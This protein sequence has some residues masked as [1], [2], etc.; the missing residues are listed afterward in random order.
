MKKEETEIT[1]NDKK[2]V[3]VGMLLIIA[4]AC[5]ANFLDLK[6]WS[7]FGCILVTAWLIYIFRSKVKI[8]VIALVLVCST[9]L[10]ALGFPV[11]AFFVLFSA[12][13][14]MCVWNHKE[15]MKASGL[16][17]VYRRQ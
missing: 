6:A 9:S 14:T 11:A 3:A 5:M 15:K 16:R 13:V 1:K 7:F 2:V 4:V 12:L 17:I 10:I 8:M